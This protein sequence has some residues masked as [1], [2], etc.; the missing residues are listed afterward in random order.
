M[1]RRQRSVRLATAG[2][3]LAAA[4]V[5]VVVAALSGSFAF[6][7]TAALVGVALGAAATRITHLELLQSRR[8]AARDRARMARQYR[9]LTEERVDEQMLFAAD[10]TGRLAK[11]EA[12]VGRL[13]KRLAEATDEVVHAHQELDRTREQLERT[14][15]RADSAE[16]ELDRLRVRLADAEERA[17]LSIVR[18]AELEQELEVALARWQAPEVVQ[19]HA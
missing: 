11:Q 1:R 7:V 12:T 4:A 3:L 16:R 10:M 19:K 9:D 2:M 17:A 8:D 18:V 15:A 6:L 13:E 14:G 5:L